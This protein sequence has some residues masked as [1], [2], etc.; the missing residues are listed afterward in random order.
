MDYFKA[1]ETIK[2][3]LEKA[4]I[5]PPDGHFAVQVR[6]SDETASG[7]LYIEVRD[8]QLFVEPYDYYDNDVDI[9][10]SVKDLKSIIEGKLDV[11]KAIDDG[12]ITVTGYTEGFIE[13]VK[14][15]PKKE[16]KPAAKKTVKKADKPAAKKTTAKAAP[17][18]AA[19]KA[20]AAKPAKKAAKKETEAVKMAD[21]NKKTTTPAEETI[22]S[23]V[24]KEIKP[25]KKTK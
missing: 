18:T 1:F 23:V 25:K 14:A 19:K 9:L 10:T 13:F 17:K 4:D 8:K 24:E 5:T 11:Q 12:K 7:I 16:K 6:L 2:A 3:A 22:A 21:E 20:S 15:I